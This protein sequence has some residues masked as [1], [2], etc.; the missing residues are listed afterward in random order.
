M[1]QDIGEPIR[2]TDVY[3]EL[4]KINGVVDVTS[5]DVGLKSGGIYSESNYDFDASLSSDGRMIE[6]QPNVIFE[7]KYPNIDI[8]GSIR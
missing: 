5:V 2:I 8:K 6:A 1:K 7:L 3:K 4:Q